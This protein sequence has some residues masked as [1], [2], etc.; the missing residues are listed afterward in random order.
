MK[1][2][3]IGSGYVGTTTAAVLATLGH[4]VI[5]AD[6]DSAKVKKLSAGILPFVE[7][8]LDEMLKDNILRGTLTFSD[9]VEEAIQA[10]DILLIAVGTP[11]LDNGTADL[12]YL[13]SVADTIAASINDYKVIVIKSTVPIGTNRWLSDYLGEKVADRTLFDVISNPEFLR[14]GHAVYD[15]L[16]PDR[17]VIGGNSQDAITIIKK[18]YHQLNSKLVICDWETA[19]L[20]KYASNA[21]LAAKISF[22]NEIAQI[23]DKTGADI[24]QIAYGVGLDPRIGT[25]FLQSGIGYG[26]S[27]FPKD[28]KALISTAD[29]IGVETHILKEIESV[30]ESMPN[31]YLAKL[32]DSLDKVTN[33]PWTISILGLT[34]K[35]E[36]DDQ[37]ESPAIK[38]VN[39][40]LPAC[41]EIRILDPTIQS[42]TKT[43]WP[44]D[45]KIIVCQTIEETL[46]GADAAV[47]CTTWD[48]F[49]SIDWNEAKA[50]MKNPILLDGR[51]LYEPNIIKA[52]GITYLALGRG[53]QT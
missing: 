32:A 6:V 25:E 40:L 21:Y 30:N 47:L 36:T 31:V 33:E 27:C 46:V 45:S 1:V 50:Y 29:L 39:K 18:L 41:K 52:A 26:G 20:I 15:T 37:R 42:N 9:Q 49:T 43:P 23:A 35:P 22:I 44:N 51:N 4:H 24:L 48:T 14:E 3:V 13:R 8:G 19:E 5:G 11:S 7:P 53:N 34:F 28:V 16:N 12:K 17:T 38:I 10:S 2:T